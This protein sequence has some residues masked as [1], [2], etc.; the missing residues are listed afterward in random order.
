[1]NTDLIWRSNEHV[2]LRTIQMHVR[3][4]TMTGIDHDILEFA[5]ACDAVE[6]NLFRVNDK[7][8]VIISKSKKNW[9]IVEHEKWD[10]VEKR[11][12]CTD[13]FFNEK[14]K[15]NKTEET[16]ISFWLNKKNSPQLKAESKRKAWPS[17]LLL[18]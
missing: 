2:L 4:N 11:D 1:M 17:L 3:Q 10:Q 18:L 12:E 9:R 5:G 6:Q 8:V 14:E 7:I 13:F 16:K 15:W